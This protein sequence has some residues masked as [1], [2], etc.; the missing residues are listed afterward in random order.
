MLIGF[1]A[2]PDWPNIKEMLSNPMG[3]QDFIF[4][5]EM[6]GFFY[7]N[8][9]LLIDRFYFGKKYLQY[10]LIIL[11]M[12]VLFVPLTWFILSKFSHHHHEPH[13]MPFMHHPPSFTVHFFNRR[14]Y[15]F[16]LV[17]AFSFLIKILQRLKRIQD[18]KTVTELSFLK[19][20]INP[21]FLFNTLNSIYSLALQNSTRA[22][23]AILKLSSMMRYVLKETQDNLVPLKE[24]INYISDFVELQRLR[25]DEYV[26]LSYEVE[27]EYTDQK[28]APMLL[29]PFIENA[30]KYGVNAEEETNILIKIIFS[31]K[32]LHLR[33]KNTKVETSFSKQTIT[34]LGISNTQKRLNL[35]YPKAHTLKLEDNEREFGIDLTLEL[36]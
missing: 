18:E 21:H 25:L 34:Q 14:L 33:V 31:K 20:Q 10:S 12:Y 2:S 16:L 27:G 3:L 15:L 19:S 6:L 28:I 4:Q 7:L 5:L 9:Y 36:V 23:Y 22:P 1:L 30:F 11:A 24:E 29:I 17:L 35:L 26:K 32:K 8:F 13:R